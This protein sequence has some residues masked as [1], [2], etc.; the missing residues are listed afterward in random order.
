MKFHRCNDSNQAIKI[1]G[2]GSGSC[3]ITQVFSDVFNTPIERLESSSSNAA[4]L[5]AAMLAA[6]ATTTATTTTTTKKKYTY[7]DLTSV[8]CRTTLVAQP[9]ADKHAR[10]RDLWMPAFKQLMSQLS[11]GKK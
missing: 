2:G 6:M 8:L 9:D 3:G 11:G 5:G 10:Y 1:T 4:A 7:S